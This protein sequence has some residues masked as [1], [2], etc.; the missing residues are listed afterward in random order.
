MLK[1][2][3]VKK[4]GLTL[5]WE[6]RD[7]VRTIEVKAGNDEK[8]FIRDNLDNISFDIT[9][10]KFY[11]VQNSGKKQ[12]RT[13]LQRALWK[14]LRGKKIPAKIARPDKFDFR[15]DQFSAA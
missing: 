4:A 1:V 12:T 6:G 9:G 15:V 10:E 13:T 14:S 11:I 8:A 7:E 5:N 2:K 3:S